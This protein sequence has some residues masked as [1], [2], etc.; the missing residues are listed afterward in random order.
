MRL[1]CGGDPSTGLEAILRGT[2]KGLEGLGA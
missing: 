1:Y 2:R